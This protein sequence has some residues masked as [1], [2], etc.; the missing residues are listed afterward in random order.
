MLKKKNRN[1]FNEEP[2]DEDGITMFAINFRKLMNSKKFRNKNAKFSENSKGDSKGT[3]HEK[4]EFD[5]KDP[6]GP[7]CFECSSYGHIR[8]DCGHLK[9]SK[10]KAYNATLSDFDNDETPGKDSNFLAFAAS[11]DSSHESIGYYSEN[12]GLEDEKNK[13]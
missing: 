2:D 9:Q 7:K 1:S 4:Y 3:N 12:S 10:G 8:A 6:C 11:Y 13:L 5:K